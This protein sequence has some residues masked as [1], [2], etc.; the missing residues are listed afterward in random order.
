MDAA[1]ILEKALEMAAGMQRSDYL[2]AACGND[3]ALKAE[4]IELIQ[5][6]EG[7]GSFLQPNDSPALA[8]TQ[9]ASSAAEKAG[10]RIGP[11]K[12]LQQIGEGGFGVVFMAEQIEPVSRKVALKVIKP[13]MDTKEVIARF[14]AERQALALMEH[15]NIAKVLDG[16]MTE[17]GRPYFVMELVKGVPITKFCDDNKLDTTNRLHLFVAVCRAIQHAHQKGVIHRDI[18]PSNVLVTLHDGEPVPRVI[19]FGVAKAISQQ[20]TEKTMFTAFGQMIG[21]P[22]YMSPEQAEMSGLDVDTRSDVYSLGVLLYELLTGST[23]LDPR[24]LRETAFDELQRMIREDEP[25]KPSSRISTLG[26]QTAQIASHRSTSPD[27]LGSTVRGDL[28]W[29]VMRSLEK[30][31][32]RRYESPN[33]FADDVGRYLDDEAVSACPP[34]LAYRF[35]KLAQRNKVAIATS[36]SIVAALVIGLSIA[37]WQAVRATNAL[38]DAIAARKSANTAMLNAEAE[39]KRASEA[40]LLAIAKSALAAEREQTVSSVT[41]FLVKEIIAKGN[42]YIET[43]RDLT[44]RDLLLEIADSP[45]STFPDDPRAEAAV[46]HYL[47]VIFHRIGLADQAQ[48]HLTRALELRQKLLGSEHLDT[49]RTKFALAYALLDFRLRYSPLEV[50]GDNAKRRRKLLDEA[51]HVLEQELGTDDPETLH[52]LALKAFGIGYTTGNQKRA[53]AV[54]QELMERAPEGLPSNQDD[55]LDLFGSVYMLV[56][57]EQIGRDADVDEE[58]KARYESCCSRLPPRHPQR[59]FWAQWRGTSLH[60]QG[61]PEEAMPLLQVSYDIRKDVLGLDNYFTFLSGRALAASQARQGNVDAAITLLEECLKH[62]PEHSGQTLNLGALYLDRNVGDDRQMWLRATVG[63]LDQYEHSDNSS[64]VNNTLKLSLVTAAVSDTE[65]AMQ[66]R[67]IE[68]AKRYRAALK[69][70]FQHDILDAPEPGAGG[71][72]IVRQNAMLA[73]ALG[74][75]RA[76]EYTK[77]R[78]L[79][80]HIEQGPLFMIRAIAFAAHAGLAA[81]QGDSKAAESL[82]RQA[83]KAADQAPVEELHHYQYFA[84]NRKHMLSV[85]LDEVQSVLSEK[86]SAEQ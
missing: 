9:L 37:V 49:A 69:D 27:K 25:P 8:V 83:K 67:A 18:K 20:L 51:L 62:F 5:A 44:V 36:A 71:L 1:T 84:W 35:R 46:R 13:G 70:R 57:R 80:I 17:S 75:Y 16:G 72:S 6:H 53:A 64:A 40:E 86:A 43:E 34:S 85:M 52:A 39:A 4:V 61:Q 74:E 65:K 81:E 59:A 12:L 76:K 3:A 14:E 78:E 32:E 28:D 68:M 2:D 73:I 48:S 60:L 24:R 23:P 15:P 31:R 77:A 21:T 82:L 7:A 79:F 42:P 11:Y 10:D 63:L 33:A 45:D 58:I 54:Y 50:K 41:D 29:I 55:P 47:G 22:Q 26:E 38:E 19:D 30:N 66:R 56:Q